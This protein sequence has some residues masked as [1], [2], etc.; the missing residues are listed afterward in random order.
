MKFYSQDGQDKFIAALLRNKKNGVFVDIGAYDGIFFSNTLHFEKYLKWTGVCVEPNPEIFNQLK[1]NRNCTCLNYCINDKKG[2]FKFLSVSG[3]GAMLSGI[4]EFFDNRHLARIDCIIR[5]HGGE[6]IIIDIAALPMEDIFREY[7]LKQID[8]CNIDV[9]GSEMKVLESIDFSKVQIKIF[10]IENNYRTKTIKNFL[11]SK[12]YKL[13]GKLGADE[14]YELNSKRYDLMLKWR[15]DKAKSFLRLLGK[16][17]KKKI[18]T[19]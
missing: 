8:Y 16:S 1:H 9:E 3:Y 14:V 17:I 4:L 7:S 11:T 12:G 6:K 19:I 15:M 10:T 2:D 18:S 13:I 5:E